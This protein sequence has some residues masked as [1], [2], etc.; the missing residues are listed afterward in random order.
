MSKAF[1]RESDDAPD[2]PSTIPMAAPLPPGA[3]NYMTVDGA[4][5]LRQEL[6]DLVQV[7]RPEWSA[8]SND[9]ETKRQ[10]QKLDQR[11]R[12]L[13]TSLHSAEIVPPP[14]LEKERVRF[15]ATV[16]VRDSRGEEEKY[17]VVGVDETDIDRGWVSWLSPISK[18][19]LNKSRGE[20]VRFQF[21]SGTEEL[22]IV[23]VFY[24]SY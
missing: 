6:N 23:D 19:L 5:R 18:A 13:Q 21:P 9:P 12:Y 4:E 17:R 11:I 14:T 1:T 22:D 20:R 15:G 3:R 24:E 7:Q 8:A 16:I 2:L 10:L